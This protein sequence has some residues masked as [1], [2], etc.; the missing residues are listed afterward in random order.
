[1]ITQR[2]HDI[3]KSLDQS[4]ARD[5]LKKN[6]EECAGTF[7]NL[8]TH[9]SKDSTIQY[10]LVLLDDILSVSTYITSF[11][12]FSNIDLVYLTCCLFI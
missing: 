2:D 7:I 3:I 1:M 8:L 10:I 9:V 11:C 4:G 12:L 6:P 5:A